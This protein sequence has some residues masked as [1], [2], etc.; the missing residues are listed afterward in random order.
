[1]AWLDLN[2][3]KFGDYSFNR[4]EDRRVRPPGEQALRQ[5]ITTE[6]G[7]EWA[8]QPLPALVNVAEPD[9]SRVLQAPLAA[10]AGGWGQVARWRTRTEPGWVKLRELV[11]AAIEPLPVADLAGTCARTPCVCGSCWVR[12][13]RYNA[14][15]PV[16]QVSALATPAGGSEPRVR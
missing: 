8:A 1:M 5:A 2:A 16:A 10:A 6:L 14:P 7:P 11:A 9:E 15:R 13:G 3:Q 12:L 4:R